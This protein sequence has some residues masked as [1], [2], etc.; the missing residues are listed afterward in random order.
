VFAEYLGGSIPITVNL[1][2]D[3]KPGDYSTGAGGTSSVERDVLDV[4]EGGVTVNA[5]V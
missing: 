4:V 2:G 1:D 5:E 3:A